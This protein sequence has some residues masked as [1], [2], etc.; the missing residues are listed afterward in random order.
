MRRS[1][2]RVIPTAHAVWRKGILGILAKGFL[3]AWSIE[4]L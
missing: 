1:S 4:K 2:K 3:A